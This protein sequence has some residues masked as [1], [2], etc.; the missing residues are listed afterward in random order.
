MNEWMNEWINGWMK[1]W[2]NKWMNEY[3]CPGEDSDSLTR[4]DPLIPLDS[5]YSAAFLY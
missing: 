4:K 2:M 3:L 5:R 1:E